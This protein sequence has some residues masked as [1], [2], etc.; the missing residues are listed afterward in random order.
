MGERFT[1]LLLGAAFAA[2]GAP[3]HAQ[4][5]DDEYIEYTGVASARH[6]PRLLYAE[7]HLLVYRASRLS[8]RLVLYTCPN[9][10]PFARKKLSYGDMQAPDFFLEDTSNGMQEGLLTHGGERSMF[11]R[12]NRF[13]AEKSAPLPQVAGLVVDAGFDEFIRAHWSALMND[14]PLPLRFLVPSRLQVVSFSVQHLRSDNVDDKPAEV[15][16]M[17]LTGLLG[18]VLPGIDVTYDAVQHVLVRYEGISDIRDKAGDNLQ[19][20]IVFHLSERRGA[21]ADVFAAAEQATIKP[22]R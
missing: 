9:G 8:E 11:F 20:S 10:A 3:C 16:R 19:A 6:A 5:A 22:C 13:E 21:S 2:W 1:A 7:H 18:I 12:A 15:F 14:A 17:N 4:A